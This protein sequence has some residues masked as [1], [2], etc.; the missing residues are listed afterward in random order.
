MRVIQVNLNDTTS[1]QDALNK[2]VQDIARTQGT[3]PKA[4]QNIPNQSQQ[5]KF[6][7]TPLQHIKQPKQTVTQES[8]DDIEFNTGI[9]TKPLEN[10]DIPEY[11]STNPMDERYERLELPSRCI[12]Y[13]FDEIFIRRLTVIEL[14]KIYRSITESNYSMFIDTIG[15][16]INQKAR[17]LTVA[18]WYFVLYWLRLHSYPKSPFIVEWT[19]KYGNKNTHT[20]KTTNLEIKSIETPIEELQ[21]YLDKG[22]TSPTVKDMEIL[23]GGELSKEKEFMFSKAQY[24]SGNTVKEKLEKLEKIDDLSILEDINEFS[25]KIEHG[26]IETVTLTDNKFEPIKAV[27]HLKNVS[28][29]IKLRAKE[30]GSTLM[31]DQAL[32]M[33]KEVEEIESS[34]KQGNIYLPKPEIRDF[35]INAKDFFI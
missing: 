19:S 12:F 5:P 27:E 16:T 31:L 17:D 8:V 15:N 18:D 26:V 13:D 9:S 20:V 25:A 34:I 6:L 22:L 30:I 29:Q 10:Q 24:L 7:G 2:G 4:K 33:D 32:D 14:G 1:V 11:K 35:S 3:Q 28:N 23:Q 21:V